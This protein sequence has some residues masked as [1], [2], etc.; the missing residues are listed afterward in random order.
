[1]QYVLFD[2]YQASLA[3]AYFLLKMSRLCL[4]KWL[5][6]DTCCDGCSG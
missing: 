1:M 6:R 2:N 4:Q 3:A 5:Y